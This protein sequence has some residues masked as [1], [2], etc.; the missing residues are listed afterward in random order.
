ME[1]VFFYNSSLASVL[2]KLGVSITGQLADFEAANK[3]Q[4]DWI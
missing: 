4:E 2:G 1:L 3:P